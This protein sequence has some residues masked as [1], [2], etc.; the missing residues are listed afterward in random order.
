MF[1]PPE[2][3]RPTANLFDF[4]VFK[5]IWMKFGTT[6]EPKTSQNAMFFRLPLPKLLPIP[7]VVVVIISPTAIAAFTGRK[8]PKLSVFDLI[9]QAFRKNSL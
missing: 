1:L 5:P 3:S 6:I 9:L 7:L 8:S 2:R 4:C